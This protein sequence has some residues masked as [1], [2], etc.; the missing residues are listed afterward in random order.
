[1]LS[2][3]LS[4]A[5]AEKH[6]MQRKPY[7]A[8]LENLG[9]VRGNRDFPIHGLK[10]ARACIGVSQLDGYTL[11]NGNTLLQRQKGGVTHW[12]QSGIPKQTPPNFI[13]HNERLL[14]EQ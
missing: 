5:G 6:S 7:R 2:S 11:L 1:M 9:H 4:T 8:E 13:T 12:S 10:A 14:K 3:G